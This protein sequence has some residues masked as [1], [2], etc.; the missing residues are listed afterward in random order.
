MPQD[1]KILNQLLLAKKMSDKEDYVAKYNIMQKLLQ[2]RPDEFYVDQDHPEYP[3]IVHA[4]TGFRMHLPRQATYGIEKKAAFS[5]SPENQD[6]L[7]ELFRDSYTKTTGKAWAKDKFLQRASNWKF[8]GPETGFI[9]TRPQRGGLEK[10]VGTA[11]N[12][13]G[14]VEAIKELKGSPD[15][16]L[17]GLVSED[18]VPLAEKHGLI[19][20]HK[21]PM[22]SSIITGLKKTIP[23]SF[24]SE[25]DIAPDGSFNLDY[26]D[27]GA[28]KKFLVG[29]PAYFNHIGK[30][31]IPMGLGKII[32]PSTIFSLLKKLPKGI[33]KHSCITKEAEGNKA[34]RRAIELAR[35]DPK[36]LQQLIDSRVFDRA[37]NSDMHLNTLF[38]DKH[39]RY[40][41]SHFDKM[42]DWLNAEKN[43]RTASYLK[44]K[45][46][47]NEATRYNII[48]RP[49]YENLLSRLDKLYENNRAHSDK[50]L[51][52]QQINTPRT[53]L[54]LGGLV[55]LDKATGNIQFKDRFKELTSSPV[56]RP[57][58]AIPIEK[59]PYDPENIIWKAHSSS[60]LKPEV[61]N[62][63]GSGKVDIAAGY[64]T[65]G[66]GKSFIHRIKTHKTKEGKP[67][68]TTDPY[69]IDPKKPFYTHHAQ[70]VAPELRIQR[71][72]ELA[73][74][75][76]VEDVKF[77]NDYL[78]LNRNY[79]WAN[80]PHYET[81]FNLDKPHTTRFMIEGDKI[82]PFKL[83]RNESLYTK[84]KEGI[85]PGGR[86]SIIPF[87]GEQLKK[88]RGKNRWAGNVNHTEL[89]RILSDP[90][91]TK[92]DQIKELGQKGF[93][94][95]GN[96]LS[97]IL[98]KGK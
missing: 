70:E 80:F 74:Q 58:L 81:V 48:G 92:L 13:R 14:I 37:N 44:K 79:G 12:P 7:Y 4:P 77:D 63:F 51:P 30:K 71:F 49:H 36:V 31:N 89:K 85:E 94:A 18:L 35:K 6:S 19:A 24:L 66:T 2:E 73:K 84:M 90:P 38:R 34:A 50:Y 9:A 82:F 61:K 93:T 56:K 46:N 62:Y 72:K 83:V 76:P 47:L 32:Q 40:F 60:T 68:I 23:S 39:Y 5:L 95:A 67:Q 33:V 16:K 52:I 27:V 65:H 25:V 41:I 1:K 10:L 45:Y 21:L 97:K 26:K 43:P 69:Q 53:T 3:G 15:T 11:G 64:Q 55:E 59:L 29:S 88:I 87:T 22:G 98:R 20:P 96:L 75:T 78:K 28:A 91:V 17:W 57:S 54:N 86:H 8:Y 42:D